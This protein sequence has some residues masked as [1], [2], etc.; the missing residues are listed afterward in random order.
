M[1]L[2]TCC[3]MFYDIF[4]ICPLI[5]KTIIEFLVCPIS[6]ILVHYKN[7]ISV[8]IVDKSET[9]SLRRNGT[10]TIVFY[11]ET[12][13]WVF[14][15][16]GKFYTWPIFIRGKSLTMGKIL[17]WGKVHTAKWV[18]WNDSPEQNRTLS[19]Q[20][21]GIFFLHIQCRTECFFRII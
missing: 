18:L 3:S 11:G 21:E 7:R 8:F 13:P 12:G 6:R 14:F 20:L 19:L 17:C 16:T 1:I 10:Y 15:S 2:N 9:D 4:S 5:W